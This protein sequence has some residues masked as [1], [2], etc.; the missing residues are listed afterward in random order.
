MGKS[1]PLSKKSAPIQVN[2]IKL[3]SKF[4]PTSFLCLY[5]PSIPSLFDKILSARNYVVYCLQFK[6]FVSIYDCRRNEVS[7]VIISKKTVHK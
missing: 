3:P 6:V 7:V 5:N 4:P 1:A 2:A